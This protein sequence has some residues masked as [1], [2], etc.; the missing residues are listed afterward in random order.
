MQVSTDARELKKERNAAVFETITDIRSILQGELTRE[1]LRRIEGVLLRL[2]AKKH[3]FPESEFPAKS[4]DRGLFPLYRL[5]EDDDHSLAMYVNSSLGSNDVPPHDHTTWA[6]TVSIQGT[7]ENRFYE[8]VG[9]YSE[10]GKGQLQLTHN[11]TVR[12]GVGVCMMPDDIHSVH[13]KNDDSALILHMYGYALDRLTNRTNF[14]LAAAT[15][16]VS[17]PTLY[18][19]EAR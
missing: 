18:I 15:Y 5:A 2:V 16:K 3:L 6:V 7:E 14:D 8:R 4:D 10:P 17:V 13:A 1:S 12:P 11:E 9:E 19:V